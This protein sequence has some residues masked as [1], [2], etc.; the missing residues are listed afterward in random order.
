M[1]MHT[2]AIIYDLN[3]KAMNA[4]GLTK[5]EIT[6]IYHQGKKVFEANGMS[7]H[8]QYSMYATKNTEDSLKTII[9]V[10]SELPSQAP[11]FC[12]YLSRFNVVHIDDSIDLTDLLQQDEDEE[13][14]A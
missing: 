3:T 1:H 4:D 7:D 12:R 6:S 11:D 13:E 14:A 10:I 9:K 8:L 2:R 5:S